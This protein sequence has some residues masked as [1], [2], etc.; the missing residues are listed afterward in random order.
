MTPL[1]KSS[2]HGRGRSP[3]ATQAATIVLGAGASRGVSYAHQGEMPSPLDSDFFDL[4]QRLTPF[5]NDVDARRRVLDA[6]NTLP[7]EYRRSMEKSFYTLQLRAHLAEHLAGAPKKDEEVIRDFARC[8]QALL[9][10]AHAMKRCAHHQRI[11]G[12]LHRQDTVI[13]C[14][15]DLV[16]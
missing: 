8:I 16:P 4:L 15:Y 5:K 3:E 10:E 2:S 9:R 11:L 13:S 12:R 7:H 1:P 6:V 14:N